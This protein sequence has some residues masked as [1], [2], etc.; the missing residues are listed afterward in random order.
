MASFDLFAP[1]LMKHEGG[2]SNNPSD[3]GGATMKGV[4]LKTYRAYFGAEKTVDDL[5]N[6][7]NLE[8]KTIMKE[9]FWDKCK[10]DQIVNQSI[11][12]LLGDWQV[13]AGYNA[14]KSVQRAFG[15]KADGI[16]GPEF[17]A[18]LNAPNRAYIF[19]RIKSERINY[20]QALCAKNPKLNTFLRSWL[21]RTNSFTYKP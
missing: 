8:W 12:E 3:P 5:K 17:L 7:S 20:Y 18:T 16:A 2:F 1:T 19:D 15:L 21:S 13:N 10:C 11:A 14:I 6:I 4:T 9:G